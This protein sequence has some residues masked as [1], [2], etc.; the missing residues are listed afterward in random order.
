MRSFFKPK[1]QERTKSSVSVDAGPVKATDASAGVA[2]ES[3]LGIG[4]LR[5]K[6]DAVQ[7]RTFTRWWNVWL[8]KRGQSEA[9]H[10]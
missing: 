9:S 4:D 10:L 1:A 3:T 5:A 2:A 6:H 8:N 7:L